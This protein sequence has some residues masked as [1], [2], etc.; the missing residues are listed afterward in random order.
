VH[1]LAGLHELLERAQ[2]LLHLLPGLFAQQ[3]GEGR[4]DMPPGGS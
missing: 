1:D 2:I 3:L 4:A